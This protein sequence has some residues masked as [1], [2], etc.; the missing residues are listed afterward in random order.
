MK[1]NRPFV[2]GL[3]GGSGS[4][5][6]TLA[7]IIEHKLPW[8]VA[9]VPLD[10]FYCDLS[11]LSF[12]ERASV[13]FD[14]PDS[15]DVHGAITSV[16][17][18]K[19][20]EIAQLPVYN[21]AEH[22]RAVE[23]D[24]VQ[25]AP[26]ILVE[27]MHSLYHLPLVELYDLTIFLDIDEQTRWERKLERDIR[28]RARTYESVSAMWKNYTKPMH[29]K[30]VQPTSSRA[31]LLFTDAFAPEVIRAVTE[32]IEHMVQLQNNQGSI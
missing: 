18:L 27:G 4:G 7:S 5:K 2:V 24:P 1:V 23:T 17:A 10:Q 21:F 11:H 22:N 29:R 8:E 28:E 6:T 13:N 9:L 16:R 15:I 19:N 25:P 32:R 20:G 12:S 26:I 3:A 30:F 31:H 14:H